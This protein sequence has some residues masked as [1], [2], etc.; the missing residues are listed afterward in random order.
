MSDTTQASAPALERRRILAALRDDLGTSLLGL[1][2]HV[3]SGAADRASIEQRVRE[4]LHKIN[5][6]I[7]ALAPGP[8]AWLEPGL[9]AR[10][11][12]V[13]NALS[14]GHTYAEIAAM[15]GVSLGTVTSHIKNSYRKLTVH[16]GAAAVARAFELG[17][18]SGPVRG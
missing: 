11:L 2:R 5:S 9:T 10:E 12:E 1:L 8:T 4:T 16:S 18:L 7:D 13:L 15:L 14:R 6:V 17:L 3:Q